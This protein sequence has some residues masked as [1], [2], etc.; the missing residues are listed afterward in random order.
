M[1]RV[2]LLILLLP[3]VMQAGALE[4][5]F[6][7]PL[8]TVKNSQAYSIQVE[9]GDVMV[10]NQRQLWVYS[11]FNAWQ[12]R[13]EASFYSTH[14]IEDEN[15]QGANRIYIASHAP[16]NTINQIDS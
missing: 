11:S 14:V 16:T 7:Y 6:V 15:L 5:R 4:R 2:L 3:I 9:D 8:S 13:L 10:R 12:P 1:K